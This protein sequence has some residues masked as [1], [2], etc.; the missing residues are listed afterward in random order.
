M[1]AAAGGG[2]VL[3]HHWPTEGG[4]PAGGP[5]A[6]TRQPA[7]CTT[8]RLGLVRQEE[9]WVSESSPPC[10]GRG[11]RGPPGP[12]HA[13][14]TVPSGGGCFSLHWAKPRFSALPQVG[15]RQQGAGHGMGGRGGSAGRGTKMQAER[16]TS[17]SVTGMTSRSRSGSRGSHRALATNGQGNGPHQAPVTPSPDLPATAKC[18]AARKNS[19]AERQDTNGG[20]ERW[21]GGGRGSVT[22]WLRDRGQLLQRARFSVCDTGGGN[23]ASGGRRP[24]RRG[25]A[26]ARGLRSGPAG[27]AWSRRSSRP[28]LESSRKRMRRRA[29]APE[30]ESRMGAAQPRP[31]CRPDAG[32]PDADGRAVFVFPFSVSRCLWRRL[33]KSADPDGL[34]SHSL[35]NHFRVR[36]FLL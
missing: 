22:C 32:E 9:K 12:S 6:S 20:S 7:A 36:G 18:P 11:R 1:G 31:P 28:V 13:S 33:P 5:L 16:P 19:P 35:T 27:G 23:A 17:R 10:G 3:A 30:S 2:G 34:L 26:C 8:L 15:P 29:A 21:G 14:V 4:G 25:A 24:R